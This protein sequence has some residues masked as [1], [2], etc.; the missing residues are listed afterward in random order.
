M[1]QQGPLSTT[2]DR[3][4]RDGRR[5][6]YDSQH[7]AK[8]VV[9]AVLTLV[10]AAL[11]AYVSWPRGQGSANT[12]AVHRADD[13]GAQESGPGQ[14]KLGPLGEKLQAEIAAALK[15]RQW[16]PLEPTMEDVINGPA[17]APEVQECGTP[18]LLS[19]VE[20]TWGSNTAPIR[21]VLVGDSVAL[22]YAGPLREIALNSDGRFQIHSEAMP[23]CS[24]IDDLL[25][26]DDQ[27]LMDACPGRRQRA[28]DYIAETQPTVVFIAHAYRRKFRAALPEMTPADWTASLRRLVD[29]LGPRKVVLLAAPPIGFELQD[30]YGK[31]GSAPADCVTGADNRWKRLAYAEQD[32]AADAKWVWMDSRPWFCAD[33]SCPAFVGT[34]PTR[35]DSVHMSPA[36]GSKISPVIAES[37]QEAGVL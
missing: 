11:V 29:K 36:Y 1:F 2:R 30:C 4:R 34:T 35:H 19:T 5:R 16:P 24:F 17:A 27:S 6:R 22:N 32:L 10:V 37:L 9:F 25:Y 7:P 8:Y 21:G 33:R 26:D 3:F 14:P 28:L 23:G 13:F 15:A 18:T 12:P 31:R 20:C